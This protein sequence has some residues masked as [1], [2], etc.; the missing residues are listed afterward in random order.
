MSQTAN[1]WNE[2][3]PIYARLP[4]VNG[5]Y[6]DEAGNNPADWLTDFWDGLLVATK[7]SIEDVRDRQLNPDTCDAGWLDLL[8]AL[9]GYTEDYWDATWEES[10]K[11]QLIRQAFVSI[12]PGKGSQAVL[13]EILE[14]FEIPHDL[15]Q[16]SRFV[17]NETL[18]P[19]TL[20]QPEWRYFIR[21]N[22]SLNRNG[23]E[24]KL[25]RRVNRLFGPAY[26]ETGVVYEQF[27]C[28]F[29]VCGEPLFS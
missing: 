29:S 19:A 27:Y 8:G 17:L 3:R 18:L 24:F 23:P 26:C 12:W 14:I 4:G 9:C 6:Y 11:R 22:L 7:A 20:G 13:Q 21:L 2:G 25:A 28:D 1:A 5:G 10:W 16:G 15:W